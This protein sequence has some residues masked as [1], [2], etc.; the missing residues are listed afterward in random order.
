MI[1]NYIIHGFC[2]ED[3]IAFTC[4]E[5]ILSKLL[6]PPTY[7]QQASE[8]VDLVWLFKNPNRDEV[9]HFALRKYKHNERPLYL[10][11]RVGEN[12]DTVK[13]ISSRNWLHWWRLTN[14]EEQ[15]IRPGDYNANQ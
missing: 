1:R 2:L 5:A 14:E 7:V 10:E 3:L 8:C 11:G 4:G 6:R 15:W 12:Y 9:S 13:C